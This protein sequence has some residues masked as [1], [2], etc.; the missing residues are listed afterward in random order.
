ML[1]GDA[2]HKTAAAVVL[3]VRVKVLV[4]IVG[5]AQRTDAGEYLFLLFRIQFGATASQHRSAYMLRTQEYVTRLQTCRLPCQRIAVPRVFLVQVGCEE[6]AI[7]IYGSLSVA[8]KVFWPAFHYREDIVIEVYIFLVEPR[9]AVQEHLYRRAV[10]DGQQPR[11]NYIPVHDGYDLVAD[12]GRQLRL[13][14][15]DEIYVSYVRHIFFD[16][17]EKIAQGS[18]VAIAFIQQRNI[19]TAFVI[20]APQGVVAV[21]VCNDYIHTEKYDVKLQI[22]GSECITLRNQL[23]RGAGENQFAAVVACVRA[24][25]ENPVGCADDVRIVLYNDYGMAL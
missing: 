13:P 15:D 21:H 2:L 7:H 22:F 23:L 10:E 24:E 19:Q 17:A 16:A 5:L 8:E 6:A 20:L 3:I 11:R 14:R 9:Y 18:P 1:A 12:P 25:V 4:E